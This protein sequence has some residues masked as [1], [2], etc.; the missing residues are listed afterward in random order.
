MQHVPIHLTQ[1]QKHPPQF[2]QTL[3]KHRQSLHPHNFLKHLPHAGEHSE[4]SPHV[5][6]SQHLK[7]N[8]QHLSFLQ[9]LPHAVKHWHWHR[10]LKIKVQGAHKL[11]L[12][13]QQLKLK[14]SHQDSFSNILPLTLLA[15]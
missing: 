7:I 3:I 11:H 1:L 12:K 9:H 13:P 6:L 8:L 2:P 15:M 4:H 10:H 5:N 14:Q